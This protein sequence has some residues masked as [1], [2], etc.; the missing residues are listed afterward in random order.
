MLHEML[1]REME[2]VERGLD[3]LC[4]MRDPEDPS[5]PP[6]LWEPNGRVPRK[7]LKVYPTEAVPAGAV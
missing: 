3:P 1:F 5:A 4:V 6:P 7:G 2:K